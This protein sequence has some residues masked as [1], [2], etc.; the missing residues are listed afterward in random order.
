MIQSGKNCTGRGT[1]VGLKTR[2]WV[3]KFCIGLV[4]ANDGK[5]KQ[6][7]GGELEKVSKSKLFYRIEQDRV[8]WNRLRKSFAQEL[9]LVY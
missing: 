1:L 5:V 7:R 2:D 3:T 9:G 4:T 6:M 8:E